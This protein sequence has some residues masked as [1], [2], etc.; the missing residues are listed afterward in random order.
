MRWRGSLEAVVDNVNH[1]A[2]K[3]SSDVFSRDP[4]RVHSL[5]PKP[6]VAPHVSFGAVSKFVRNPIHFNRQARGFAEEEE[7]ENEGSERMLP[8]KL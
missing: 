7:V 6:F 8:S 5:R 1:H 2:L 3:I 4:Q